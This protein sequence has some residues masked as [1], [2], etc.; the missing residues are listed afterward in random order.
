M[1]GAAAHGSCDPLLLRRRR[2]RRWVRRRQPRRLL[3]SAAAAADTA[4]R[5]LRRRSRRHAGKVEEQKLS[6][7]ARARRSFDLLAE[8]RQLLEAVAVLLGHL[9]DLVGSAVWGDGKRQRRLSLG[10]VSQQVFTRGGPAQ[11]RRVERDERV[12]HSLSL[13]LRDEARLLRGR[14]RRRDFLER[15]CERGR[16]RRGRRVVHGLGRRRWRGLLSHGDGCQHRR[17]QR[18]RRRR[19]RAAGCLGD[20]HLFVN[21]LGGR[22]LRWGW[23]A[24]RHGDIYATPAVGEAGCVRA[25]RM[26]VEIRV[27]YSVFEGWRRLAFAMRTLV[28][29]N[30]SERSELRVLQRSRSFLLVKLV[31]GNMLTCKLFVRPQPALAARPLRRGAAAAAA[32]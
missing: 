23:T 2:S 15:P 30:L 10:Q 29:P 24:C 4:V 7:G 5:C 20:L 19:R 8:L 6:L 22:R 26:L 27:V 14:L 28:V 1:R 9:R 21:V 13:C 18:L 16:C 12:Q 32:A 31:F 3:V 17:R 25:D 11:R